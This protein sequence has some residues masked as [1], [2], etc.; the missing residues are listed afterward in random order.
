MSDAEWAKIVAEAKKEGKVTLYSWS[1]TGWEA[2]WLNKTVKAATGIEVE[3]LRFSGT[4]ATE[5]IKT[6]A[7]AGKNV[8]DVFQSMTQYYTGMEATGLLK[9]IDN[10]PA[11]KDVGDPEKWYVSPILSKLTLSLSKNAKVGAGW[12]YYSNKVVPPERL[13]KDFRDILDPWWTGKI[14]DTDPITYSGLD[15]RL[16]KGY[17]A[18][19]YPDWWPEF[20]YQYMI[21]GQR[22]VWSILGAPSPMPSGGCGI[23]LDHHGTTPGDI[24]A[25]DL[26]DN[27]PWIRAGNF[28][29]A[30]PLDIAQANGISILA[31]S[32][33][34]NAALVVTNWLLSKEGLQAW[35]DAGNGAVLRRDVPDKVE[36]KYKISNPTDKLFLWDLSW[37]GF[38]EYSY[39]KKDGT[40]KL[41]KE[42][43]SKDAWLKWMKDTSTNYWGQ[44]PP[45][46]LQLFSTSD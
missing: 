43:M 16:W 1:Y 45:P 37:Y 41:V 40:F 26:K 7:R 35:V 25:Y 6:E 30:V 42:G 8:A 38:I 31:K 15:H 23:F 3:S 13:P 12:Y 17:A 18:L 10:L 29:P 33:H 2:E 39:G 14:C 34:P 11:L 20:W 46:A 28:T 19:G 44:Y 27:T 21:K 24:K 5:R 36:D 32:P 9:P 4:I 22:S